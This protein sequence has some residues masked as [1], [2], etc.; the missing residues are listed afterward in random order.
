MVCFVSSHD[1]SK[2]VSLTCIWLLQNLINVEWLNVS[3]RLV[4]TAEL[5]DGIGQQGEYANNYQDNTLL[6]DSCN[7]Q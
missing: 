3:V 7:M 1:L 2:Q 5:G 6:D 4:C